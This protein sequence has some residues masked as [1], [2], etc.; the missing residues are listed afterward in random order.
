MSVQDEAARQERRLK[1]FFPATM[2]AREGGS[3]RVHVLDL[4]RG[5][6]RLHVGDAMAPDEVVVLDLFGSSHSAKVAWASAK[7]VGVRFIFGLSGAELSAI[8][9]ARAMTLRREAKR[10]GA[11]LAHVIA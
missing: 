8:D 4:S 7:Q 2:I 9:D 1:V 6:A 3:R 11:P 10:L 5:G